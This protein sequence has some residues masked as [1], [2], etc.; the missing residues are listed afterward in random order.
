MGASNFDRVVSEVREHTLPARRWHLFRLSIG[1]IPPGPPSDGKPTGSLPNYALVEKDPLATFLSLELIP[2]SCR[3]GFALSGGS[4]RPDVA[5][6]SPSNLNIRGRQGFSG[7]RT[8]NGDI[9]MNDRGN[10]GFVISLL[11]ASCL[12]ARSAWGQPPADPLTA[13]LDRDNDGAVSASE[14]EQAVESLRSLDKNQDGK[15]TS[16]EFMPDFPGFG[17]PGFGGRGPRMEKRLLISEFDKDGDGRL[18][19]EE[20]TAAR[21]SLEEDRSNGP[22]GRGRRG[23]GGRGRGAERPPATPGPHVTPAEVQVFPN[24]SLYD[25][26]VLRTLFLDFEHDD[27]ND[28]M[29]AF[30]DSDV[31]V[32]ATLTVD[33]R[34][35][36]N[37]GVHFRGMSSF[38]M[39]SEEY[40]RSLDL[41]LDFVDDNQRLYGYRTLNL[42][43]CAGDSSMMSAALYSYIASQFIPVSRANFVKVVIN[44]ESWGIYANLQQFN[45]DFVREHYSTGKG[46]RWKVRGNPGADGGLRYLGDDL[47][48]Y[49][50]RFQLKSTEDEKAWRRLIELCRTLEQTPTDELEAA[51]RPMIDVDELLWFLAIDVALVNSDGYWTCASDYNLY[52]DGNEKFHV[53]PGDVN[54]AFHGARRRGPGGPGGFRGFGPPG[55]FGPPDDGPRDDGTPGGGPPE[56]TVERRGP[57]RGFGGGPPNEGGIDLDPLVNTDNPRMPLRTKVLSRSS[58]SRT[59]LAE[60]THDRGGHELGTHGAGCSAAPGTDRTRS[61]SGHSQAVDLRGL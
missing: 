53:I 40:K 48:E 18:N 8:V 25:S 35:Y 17:P 42:L 44:G 15:L 31:E 3:L 11:L 26:T 4:G 57:R 20:R 28:E 46:S 59:V 39:V 43:N 21:T 7:G 16:E 61:Q 45:K 19:R 37:V 14:M 60:C 34:V 27:W 33:G 23:P 36:P 51:L 55:G 50:Q 5:R 38:M 24:A 47:D 6:Y 29:A 2:A 10:R 12:M 52:L 1:P 54:E 56:D 49:K 13:A 58:I 22:F 9:F 32:P 30:K 41:S